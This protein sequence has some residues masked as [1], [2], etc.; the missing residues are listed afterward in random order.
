MINVDM[1]NNYEQGVLAATPSNGLALG[2]Y[3]PSHFYHDL[4]IIGCNIHNNGGAGVLCEEG[5]ILIDASTTIENNNLRNINLAQGVVIAPGYPDADAAWLEPIVKSTNHIGDVES[6]GL[7][8]TG[9]VSFEPQ[10]TAA[11]TDMYKTA[12][13]AETFYKATVVLIDVG[14]SAGR[15]E[16]GSNVILKGAGAGGADS[17]SGRVIQINED[18]CEILF[19][20]PQDLVGNAALLTTPAGTITSQS[21]VSLG[22]ALLIGSDTSWEGEFKGGEWI[23]DGTEWRQLLRV[24]DDVSLRLASPFTN[25]PTTISYLRCDVQLVPTPFNLSRAFSFHTTGKIYVDA[26]YV[27]FG[28]QTKMLFFSYDVFEAGSVIYIDETV[29]PSGVTN[30]NVGLVGLPDADLTDF[31]AIIL[32]DF[33][34]GDGNCEFRYR[35]VVSNDFYSLET[36]PAVKN[37]KFSDTRIV[38]DTNETFQHTDASTERFVIRHGN[39]TSGSVRIEARLKIAEMQN[40]LDV[41]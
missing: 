27:G 2:V 28:Q 29:T 21:D 1:F 35:D 17:L 7:T 23:T 14:T 13:A 22:T 39:A 36:I 25:T 26:K 32:E 20:A 38:L 30:Q 4:S 11:V 24:D 18:V 37:S 40:F 34:G 3:D 12:E 10:S 41:A 9:A 6:T 19:E 16:E 5:G 8:I 31:R 33:G 15:L